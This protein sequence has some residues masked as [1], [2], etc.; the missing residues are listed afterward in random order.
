MYGEA[1]A[2]IARHLTLNMRF[3]DSIAYYRKAIEADP[4]LWSARSELG[5][6]LMRFGQTD[7]PLQQLEMSYNNGYRDAATVNS[8]RLL[9]SYKNFETFKEDAT[10]IKLHK[11]EAD[12]LLPYVRAELKRVIG[13][14][15]KK[16][17]MKLPGS[18]QVELY[19]DHD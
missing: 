8:L 14:Y 9:D 2:I 1:Y 15:A 5:I 13:T 10:I 19:P 17:K 4:K 3:Q 6:Q 12:L 18:A 11:K 16:Y 7:E